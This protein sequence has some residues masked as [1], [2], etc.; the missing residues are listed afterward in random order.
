LNDVTAIQFRSLQKLYGSLPVAFMFPL[1]PILL[2]FLAVLD[3]VCAVQPL[4]SAARLRQ[5]APS[6]HRF[7]KRQTGQNTTTTNSTSNANATT[8]AAA[9]VPLILASDKQ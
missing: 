5:L 3:A 6:L 9:T 8:T 7:I 4:D 2:V 1:F